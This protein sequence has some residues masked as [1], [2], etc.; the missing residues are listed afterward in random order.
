MYSCVTAHH[1]LHCHDKQGARCD[2]THYDVSVQE[3]DAYMQDA[4]TNLSHSSDERQQLLTDWEKGPSA[5]TCHPREEHL[6]PLM[7]TAGAALYKPAEV[8]FSDKLMGAQIS[9]YIWN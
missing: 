9:G 8:A 5:R 6:L 2:C 1:Q 3:F 7:V 4:L